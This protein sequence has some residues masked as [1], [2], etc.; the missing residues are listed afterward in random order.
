MKYCHWLSI[1]FSYDREFEKLNDVCETSKSKY[2]EL[3]KKTTK[4]AEDLKHLANKVCL[5]VIKWSHLLYGGFET[6]IKF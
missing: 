3:E 1:F 4:A 5:S 6:S 2:G